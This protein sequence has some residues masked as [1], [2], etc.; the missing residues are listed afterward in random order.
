MTTADEMLV[1]VGCAIPAEPSLGGEIRLGRG[2]GSLFTKSGVD[3]DRVS[4]RPPPLPLVLHSSEGEV[5]NEGAVVV[6][7]VVVVVFSLVLDIERLRC[8]SYR[9][10]SI[11]EF[12]LG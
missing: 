7:V 6:D 9:V 12:G 1:L 11:C 4:C 5:G 2:C 10:A 8:F 3:G